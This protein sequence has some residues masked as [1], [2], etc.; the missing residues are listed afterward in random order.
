[1]WR[2]VL[3]TTGTPGLD[4]SSAGVGV[5][6]VTDPAALAIVA[7]DDEAPLVLVSHTSDARAAA[8]AATFVVAH[9]PD[10]LVC[11]VASAHA[12]LA[13]LVA[14][15]TA[16]DAT[17]DA[18]HGV[19]LWRDLLARSWSAVVLRS[20]TG[21]RDPNPPLLQHLRSWVP[22]SRFLVRLGPEPVSVRADRTAPALT[23]LGRGTGDMFVTDDGADDEVTRELTRTLAPTGVR[24][25]TLPGS[26]SSLFGRAEE[27]QLA[28]LP[29]VRPGLLAPAGPAC[30]GCGL[31]TS[32]V[33]C[34][35]C[36]TRTGHETAD[37]GAASARPGAMPHEPADLFPTGGPA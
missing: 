23:G 12:P 9:R 37:P 36:R 4:E 5:V 25:L 24:P 22:G 29:S 14:L 28:L 15:G 27:L 30:T 8:V 33:V 35:F 21:L 2:A 32:G 1:M 19:A 3:A 31:A 26:W 10:R 16:L 6:D 17:R 7:E 20:V 18:G 34:Q 11:H 13:L